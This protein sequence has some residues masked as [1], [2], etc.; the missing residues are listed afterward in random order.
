MASRGG[1]APRL[2]IVIPA[3]DAAT[4]EDTLVSVLEN[5]PEDCEIVAVLAVPYADPWSIGNEVRFVQAPAAATLVDCVNVGMASSAGRIVHVLRAGWRATDGWAD[6]ALERFADPDVI[7]V[8][9]LTV[10]AGDRGRVVAAGV[11]RTSGGRSMVNVPARRDQRIETV[12]ATSVAA[13]GAPALEAG[14]W[15]AEAVPASG[16]SKACGDRLAAADMA[17]AVACM[18]DTVVVEPACQVVEG[19][20][21]KRRSWFTEGLHAERLFW[22]SL[23]GEQPIAALMAHV[24]EVIRHAVAA[25]PLGTLP[26]L[27]GR[28]ACLMQFGSCLGRARELNALQAEAGARRRA[29]ADD[30]GSRI[31]RIDAAHATVGRPQRRGVAVA[32]SVSPAVEGRDSSLRRSA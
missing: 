24:G 32:G 9:P 21:T 11:R 30:S 2:S 31:V 10:A 12:A 14:F 8:V 28:L 18:G 3:F 17:A 5:R 13:P 25:A 15:R 27:A 1:P 6:A 26:M 19:P 20:A 4:L 23:A 29:A 16:F 7:A 22:R